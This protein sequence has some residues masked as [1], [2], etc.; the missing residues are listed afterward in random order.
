M[1]YISSVHFVMYMGNTLGS[2]VCL[3]SVWRLSELTNNTVHILSHFHYV[4]L[5]VTYD[6][7]KMIAKRRK[8]GL[9]TKTNLIFFL[10]SACL[11]FHLSINMKI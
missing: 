4:V 5:S 8:N 2:P 10:I 1:I 7:Q 6:R 3:F 11:A 9:A